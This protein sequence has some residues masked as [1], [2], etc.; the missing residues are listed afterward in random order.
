MSYKQENI[1]IR[2]VQHGG[3]ADIGGY[4]VTMP[5]T[6][7]DVPNC[8]CV[9]KTQPTKEILHTIVTVSDAIRYLNSKK[10]HRI[11]IMQDYDGDDLNEDYHLVEQDKIYYPVVWGRWWVRPSWCEHHNNP[12]KCNWCKHPEL[13]S[14]MDFI[15]MKN[16]LVSMKEVNSELYNKL[17]DKYQSIKKA[18]EGIGITFKSDG[19]YIHT[20]ASKSKQSSLLHNLFYK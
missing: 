7:M 9:D 6:Y 14:E 15:R 13:T 5:R 8:T 10:N 3:H 12:T 20:E 16:T 18:L 4:P 2:L 17:H 1:T 19:R 11:D